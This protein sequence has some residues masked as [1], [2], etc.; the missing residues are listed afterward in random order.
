MSEHRSIYIITSEIYGKKRTRKLMHRE[1][2]D[3]TC[4]CIGFVCI[5]RAEMWFFLRFL[6][7][8]TRIYASRGI[9]FKII[10]SEAIERTA[11]Q[12]RL[13]RKS[14]AK[15]ETAAPRKHELHVV[16]QTWWTACR[17]GF[18]FSAVRRN[19]SARSGWAGERTGCIISV[20]CQKG[21]SRGRLLCGVFAETDGGHRSWSQVTK[22]SPVA[23]LTRGAGF[24]T[25]LATKRVH[26]WHCLRACW[27]CRLSG[28]T[29]GTWIRIGIGIRSPE[30]GGHVDV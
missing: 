17:W 30:T 14:L 4:I 29:T 8:A 28:S 25:V 24:L 13:T 22:A 15:I 9:H 7:S 19:V 16:N 12:G 26:H 27:K 20:C 6:C 1:T 2:T 11:F 23:K 10:I 21:K 18:R 3:K 5:L